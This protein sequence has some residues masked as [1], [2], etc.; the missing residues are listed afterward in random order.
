MGREMDRAIAKLYRLNDARLAHYDPVLERQCAAF[1]AAQAELEKALEGLF[2][3]AQRELATL[4]A[5]APEARPLHSL[6]NHREGLSV[7][8][9]RPGCRWTTILRREC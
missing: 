8:L 5:Q 9:E 1:D 7:F 2:T 3:Q 6:L 4:P